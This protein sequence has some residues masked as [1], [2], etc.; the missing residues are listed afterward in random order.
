MN[1][2]DAIKVMKEKVTDM[3]AQEYLKNIPRAI[4]E[5]GLNGLCIQMKYVM[6]NTKTW[7]GDEAK[8]IKEFVKTWIDEKSNKP[9]D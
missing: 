7:R 4:D 3:Y 9:N 8:E 6:E 1:I 5:G 2:N